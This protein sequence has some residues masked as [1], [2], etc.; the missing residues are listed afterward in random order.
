MSPCSCET[1]CQLCG[2]PGIRVV[3]SHDCPLRPTA[4]AGAG[5]P[6]PIRSVK[7]A[8]GKGSDVAQVGQGPC[9]MPEPWD[10]PRRG[11]FPGG[12]RGLW[13]APFFFC[14]MAPFAPVT[15]PWRC[16]CSFLPKRRPGAGTEARHRMSGRVP[17]CRS[18]GPP[19][20]PKPCSHWNLELGQPL[21]LWSLA[22]FKGAGLVDTVPAMV[23]PWAR[24][25]TRPPGVTEHIQ[26]TSRLAEGRGW[27]GPNEGSQLHRRRGRWWAGGG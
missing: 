14:R 12:G 1:G 21:E 16:Q 7:T 20:V 8:A 24:G 5:Q 9:L 3:L 17:S 23:G 2:R 10:S 18:P 26:R 11:Q 4:V 15:S 22:S 13:F 25:G 6:L 27:C 19:T